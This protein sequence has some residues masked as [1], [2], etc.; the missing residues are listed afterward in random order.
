MPRYSCAPSPFFCPL[1]VV[2]A[3]VGS[4]RARLLPR[5]LLSFPRSFAQPPAFYPSN[6]HST[7]PGS[8]NRLYPARFA[9]SPPFQ[10]GARRIQSLSLCEWLKVRAQFCGK[11]F[12]GSFCWLRSLA[13]RS[14]SIAPCSVPGSRGA[15]RIRFR[16][17]GHIVPSH[18]LAQRVA[19]CFW[20]WQDSDGSGTSAG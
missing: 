1:F 15:H 16:G 3:S 9:P 8:F 20:V 5:P 10:S 6:P 2:P 4:F 14:I 11:E 17:H 12:D 18:T 19:S 7:S 13:P